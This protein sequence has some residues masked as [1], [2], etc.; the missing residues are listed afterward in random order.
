MEEL[1][2]SKILKPEVLSKSSEQ[3]DQLQRNQVVSGKDKRTVSFLA[4]GTY[5]KK[6]T[7]SSGEHTN[8]SQAGPEKQHLTSSV[9][10]I[11]P[12]EDKI[13]MAAQSS[14]SKNRDDTVLSIRSIEADEITLETGRYMM[15][16][17]AFVFKLVA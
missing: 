9:K 12:H 15:I 16:L 6:T 8:N 4:E 7:F 11:D 10:H 13:H 1:G 5:K 17:F 14:G 2:V 3:L